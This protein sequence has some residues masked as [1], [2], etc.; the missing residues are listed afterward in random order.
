MTETPT[1]LQIAEYLNRTPHARALGLA[2]VS[3]SAGRAEMVMPYSA[4]LVGDPE[5]RV[6]AGGAIT[7]LL[8]QIC[9]IAV[10]TALE[11][12]AAIATLDLRIDYM[13]PAP[14]DLPVRAQAHCFKQTRT[15]A[16]VRA[17]AFVSDPD[18]PIATATAT[19][20]LPS[21]DPAAAG[22]PT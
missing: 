12:P 6:I 11:T 21:A 14:P 10:M 18:D 3:V 7:A 22:A 4:E 15:I 17:T 13:R 16:F 1:P 19:F 2:L 5:T 20:I 8:D 9:G